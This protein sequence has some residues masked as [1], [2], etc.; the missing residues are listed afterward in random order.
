MNT[1]QEYGTLPILGKSVS[2]IRPFDD[3]SYVTSCQ[4]HQEISANINKLFIDLD[5]RTEFEREKFIK[6]VTEIR[7]PTCSTKKCYEIIFRE[8]I[9]KKSY[10]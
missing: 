10:V 1:I 5:K 4:E 8:A 6:D 3:L 2:Q 7:I 9:R